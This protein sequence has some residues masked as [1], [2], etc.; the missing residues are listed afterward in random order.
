MS[1]STG[2]TF[3]EKR[4]SVVGLII[5]AALAL[6]AVVGLLYD[7]P[8]AG[9]GAIVVFVKLYLLLALIE[10]VVW[11]TTDETRPKHERKLARP[12]LTASL[13]ILP[14]L[15]IAA[16]FSFAAMYRQLTCGIIHTTAETQSIYGA[17]RES[18]LTAQDA[19]CI[20]TERV[21]P[22]RSRLDAVYFSA[23]TITTVGYG[24]FVPGRPAARLLV[25]WEIATGVFL[26]AGAFP[27]IVSRLAES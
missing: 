3:A 13:V 14:L 17:K 2:R 1:A 5:A 12:S 23:V 24:D 7:W 16:V 9:M 8:L 19:T 18:A 22:L 15:L 10:K 21:E 4:A 20:V 25:L 6:A 27:L 11:S 26:I